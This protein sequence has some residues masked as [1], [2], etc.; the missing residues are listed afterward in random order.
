MITILHRSKTLIKS[1][2][3]EGVDEGLRV[4]ALSRA[5]AGS[6]VP[7]PIGHY[8]SDNHVLVFP[9]LDGQDA[10]KLIH[11]AL[12]E[13]SCMD[14][15]WSLVLTPLVK[16]HKTTLERAYIANPNIVAPSLT[17]IDPLKHVSRR[18][19]ILSG[20]ALGSAVL[21]LH[22]HLNAA[23][24]E[25][26]RR[27]ALTVIHG[28]FHVGQVVVNRDQTESAIVDLDDV[29]LGVAEMDIANCVAHITT[30]PIC[31]IRSDSRLTKDVGIEQKFDD[32][33]DLLCGEY[34]QI[35]E[36]KLSP[37]RVCL[38]GASALLRRALKLMETANHDISTQSIVQAAQALYSRTCYHTDRVE[39]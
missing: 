21:D 29:G 15:I 7:T 37:E 11:A 20:H 18:L 4:A 26:I 39:V 35:A 31:K 14:W 22:R 25:D 8:D 27:A 12:A 32:W 38:Y 3:D 23:I 2:Q 13:A 9:L 10:G 16:L 6:R 34:E 33:A 19:N 30:S 1:L 5:L 17:V 28:D 24:D 36:I